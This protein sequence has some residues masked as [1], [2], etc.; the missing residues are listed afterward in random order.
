VIVGAEDILTP[1]RLSRTL[2]ER[3]PGARLTVI[4]E[5]GHLVGW[6]K[7]MEFNQAVLGFLKEH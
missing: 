3:I 2:A 5:A 7:A 6:E 1:P 4:P